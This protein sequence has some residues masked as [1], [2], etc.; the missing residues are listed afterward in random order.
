LRAAYRERQD[1]LKDLQRLYRIRLRQAILAARQVRRA[2]AAPDLVA[3]EQRHAI[4]QLRTLDRHHLNQ[5]QAVHA[6]FGERIQPAESPSLADNIAEIEK[7][8]ADCQTILIT[9]GNVVVLLNR[10]RLFVADNLFASRHIVAWSAGAM[11][12]S[13]LIVLYHD[14]T[15]QGRRD[16]EV[17]GE[18]AG[19]LPGYVFL[20]DA[21]HRLKSKDRVRIGVFRERF[22][23]A[24][25]VTLNSGSVIQ[26]DGTALRDA[27]AAGCLMPDGRIARLRAS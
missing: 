17:L 20:P 16:P 19:V 14:R 8:A 6:E 22:S 5:V 13:D 12:L 27:E 10:L 26:F 24:R 21:T 25:C 9:G 11:V 18:G 23:P 2:T 15:P 4:T 7:A 1:R 3:S